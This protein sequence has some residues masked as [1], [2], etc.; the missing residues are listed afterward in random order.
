M[1][2]D[3][4]ITVVFVGDHT[5]WREILAIVT[6]FRKIIRIMIILSPMNGHSG[7]ESAI[8][9]IFSGMARALPQSG[10]KPINHLKFLSYVTDYQ[11][12]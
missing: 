10:Q 1:F 6:K 12:D 11:K 9:T 2:P 7:A 5:H 8:L 4:T 3:K